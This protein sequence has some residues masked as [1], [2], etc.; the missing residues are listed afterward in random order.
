MEENKRQPNPDHWLN[1]VS[2]HW[3]IYYATVKRML[4]MY[5]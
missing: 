3:S 4:Q 2:V 5:I 1:V